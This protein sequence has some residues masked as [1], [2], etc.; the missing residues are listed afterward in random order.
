[1]GISKWVTSID[2]AAKSERDK[3][4]ICIWPY[5]GEIPMD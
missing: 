1:M 5:L 4:Q 2:A 3:V